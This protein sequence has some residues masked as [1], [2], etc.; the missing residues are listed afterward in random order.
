MLIQKA[1]LGSMYGIDPLVKAGPRVSFQLG[2]HISVE[3]LHYPHFSQLLLFQ[4]L[5]IHLLS[6]LLGFLLDLPDKRQ[7]YQIGHSG[8][9]LSFAVAAFCLQTGSPPLLGPLYAL[10]QGRSSIPELAEC[11]GGYESK[12]FM[13][14]SIYP[15][16][17]KYFFLAFLMI[18][19]GDSARIFLRRLSFLR[20]GSLVV[21]CLGTSLSLICR[22]LVSDI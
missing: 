21:R 7:I 14:V 15:M 17:L 20:R 22:Y 5:G 1:K 2:L 9:Q 16:G 6:I 12:C 10:Y 3:L 8:L 18:S 13:M 4:Y 19:P 11:R